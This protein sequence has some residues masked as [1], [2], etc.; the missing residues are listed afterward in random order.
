[1][2]LF[3]QPEAETPKELRKRGRQIEARKGLAHAVAGALREGHEAR[4]LPAVHLL[5][6]SCVLSPLLHK[7]TQ[8]VIHCSCV[9]PI[10]PRLAHYRS[11]TWCFAALQLCSFGGP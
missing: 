9:P 1:M 6:A 4:R 2:H 11:P 5:H 8:S 10:A 3:S 7:A